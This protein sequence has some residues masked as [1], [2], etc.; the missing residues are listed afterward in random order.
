MLPD[1][2]LLFQQIQIPVG[3]TQK[4]CVFGR[5]FYPH[6]PPTKTLHT[7][8]YAE[9]HALARGSATLL[10]DGETVALTPGDVVLIPENTFHM[11]T[12]YSPDTE[13]TAFMVEL[14]AR[15]ACVSRQSVEL[16]TF[17]MNEIRKCAGT[18]N[19]TAV[20]PYLSLLCSC[21]SPEDGI[22]PQVVTD[23]AFMI[24]QYICKHYDR[25]PNANELA[26]QLH[27]SP[28]Q[29]ARLVQQHTGMPFKQ[30]VLAYR[31]AVSRHL[32][33]HTGLSLAQISQKV[34][35]RTYNGFW[36]AYTRYCREPKKTLP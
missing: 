2:N 8:N 11:Y 23:H 32:A 20:V 19:M 25:E 16:L 36:K 22:T 24:H 6:T 31:M 27:F 26:Q 1:E 18:G 29:T 28:R 14:H 17:F 21:F 4:N 7:H 9:I 15:E 30:A 5:G 12:A 33:E 3:A 10:L 13:H 34:G 35:Y